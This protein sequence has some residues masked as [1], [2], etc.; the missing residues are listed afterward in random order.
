VL[1]PPDLAS[2]TIVAH[3]RD[4]YGLSVHQ[5]TFLPLG[6]DF[7]AAVYRLEADHGGPYFLKLRRG[8][9]DEVSVDVPAYLHAQGIQQVMAPLPTCA[10]QLWTSGQGFTWILYPFMQGANA[11]R[12]LLTKAQWIA[13]GACLRA[14]HM[15]SPPLELRQRTPREDFSFPLRGVVEAFDGRLDVYLREGDHF[16]ADLAAFWLTRRAEIHAILERTGQLAQ[17]LRR[18]A[19]AFVLCHSDL[20]PG[21]LLVGDDGQFA[22]VDWDAPIFAPKER[23][24]ILTAGGVGET[25]SDLQDEAWFYQGYCEGYGPVTPDLDAL[26][27]YRYDRIVADLASY[28]E[29]IFGEQGSEEDRTEAYDR[30]TSQFLP[31]QVIEV[32]H[33]THTA[34]E[35]NLRDE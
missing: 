33:R 9:F 8:D 26:V 27:Y 17:S 1:T 16:A 21:N 30:V 34:Y 5:V 20:H 15:T 19:P 25:W 12:N 4:V 29:Q 23:D 31:N 28:G 3:M 24:L 2:E 11:Y 22:I 10:G 6:A 13:F 18:R 35:V 14:I 32:A 7:N